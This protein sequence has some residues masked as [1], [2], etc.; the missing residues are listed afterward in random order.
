MLV[1]GCVLMRPAVFKATKRAA[2]CF[3]VG[4]AVKEHAHRRPLTARRAQHVVR[5]V[6]AVTATFSPRFIVY[7]VLG[8][9][10]PSLP[11][12]LLGSGTVASLLGLFLGQFL[13]ARALSRQ[14]PVRLLSRVV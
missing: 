14:L 2:A 12:P 1:P 5:A 6:N 8:H 9:S 13:Q 4:K 11:L 7:L 10:L 3:A